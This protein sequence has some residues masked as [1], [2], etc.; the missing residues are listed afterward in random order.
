MMK[1][2]RTRSGRYT[3][4]NCEQPIPAAS[5]KYCGMVCQHAYQNKLIVEEWLS[6]Q[7]TGSDAANALRKPIRN[8]LLEQAGYACTKCGW[9]EKNPILDR[10]ILTVDH[11]D[12]NWQ[13]NSVDNLEVLC[14]NCH[15]LTSTFGTL[16]KTNPLKQSGRRI[17]T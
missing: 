12:G 6:G 16:N 17:G 5:K 2:K 13:N 3:C 10:P 4:L 14:Y 7:I 15:T 8:W 11:K 1:P 9:S